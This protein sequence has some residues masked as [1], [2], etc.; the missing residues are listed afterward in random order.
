MYPW[1]QTWPRVSKLSPSSSRLS[2]SSLLPQFTVLSYTPKVGS[3]EGRGYPK[4]K[5]DGKK[6]RRKETEAERES[7]GKAGKGREWGGIFT[8][9]SE[10]GS[11]TTRNQMTLPSSPLNFPSAS[12]P[13][14]PTSTHLEPTDYPHA[15]N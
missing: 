7:E 3:G 2:T 15:A 8:G 4:E 6:K 14:H 9:H 10:F 13:C 1:T 5:G 11:P 12:S